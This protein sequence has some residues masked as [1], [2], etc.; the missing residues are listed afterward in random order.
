V[1]RY[2][3]ADDERREKLSGLKKEDEVSDGGGVSGGHGSS[4]TVHL[5][6]V[7]LSNDDSDEGFA[8]RGKGG[9]MLDFP[10]KRIS[11][12]IPIMASHAP[13]LRGSAW[14]A[15]PR[16]GGADSVAECGCCCPCLAV[17]H[18]DGAA[19]PFFLSDRGILNRKVLSASCSSSTGILQ[20]TRWKEQAVCG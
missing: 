14:V 16:T 8:W 12:T 13:R 3:L 6:S 7:R 10:R 1:P 11:F 4:T 2:G 19:S 20:E 15:L 5:E 18:A 9:L 17:M